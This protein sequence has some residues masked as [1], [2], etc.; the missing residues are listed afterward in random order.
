MELDRQVRE[1]LNDEG[2]TDGRPPERALVALFAS[3]TPEVASRLLR[4][5]VLRALAELEG[6]AMRDR[7]AVVETVTRKRS[8]DGIDESEWDFPG[9]D[10]LLEALQAEDASSR[11]Q[12]ATLK[13]LGNAVEAASLCVGAVIEARDHDRDPAD[14]ANY[15]RRFAANERPD[16]SLVTPQRLALR[17][18]DRQEVW[19][20]L[21][22]ESLKEIDPS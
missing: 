14:W 8:L 21:L 11:L 16:H 4:R 3:A 7:V 10:Y 1:L 15:R 20:L 2:W 5:L 18:R 6:Q 22:A 12:K 19:R 13:S 17:K 9:G